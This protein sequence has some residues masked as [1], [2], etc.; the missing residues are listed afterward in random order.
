MIHMKGGEILEEGIAPSRKG[1]II[2]VSNLFFNTPAR[3][4]YLK[5]EPAE[6]ANSGPH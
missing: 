4:K 2:T 3:L 5:S 6:L 1:T